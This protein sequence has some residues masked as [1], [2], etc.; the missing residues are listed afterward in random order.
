MRTVLLVSPRFPP[1]NAPDHQRVRMM[2]PH[3][4]GLGWDPVVLA[5][6][7]E[8]ELGAQEPELAAR[9]TARR[10]SA[11]TLLTPRI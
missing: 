10:T 2:I 6:A 7:T 8:P 11:I 9:S 1:L 3:L 5:L 4:R